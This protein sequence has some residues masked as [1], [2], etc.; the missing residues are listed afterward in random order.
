MKI[1][2]RILLPLVVALI[3]LASATSAMAQG[4]QTW[5]PEFQ[6]DKH[7]YIDSRL[8]EHR[9]NPV[10]LP[11]LP[12]EIERAQK[13]HG[14]K[15][16]VVATEQGSE[17][18]ASTALAAQKLD[19]LILK[20]RNDPN[21]PTDD[22]LVVMWVRFSADP[23]RGSVAANGGNRLRGYGMS[24][25]HFGASD[26]PVIP[27]LKQHMRERPELALTLIINNV[28]DEVTSAISAET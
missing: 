7:V 6:P 11:N 22:Y 19:E 8:E 2:N 15:V 28:N 23:T 17:A 9:T 21:F 5:M 13:V 3:A 26:G 14:L 16:Y 1:L 27:V 10:S 12:A 25:D 20:W 24:A 4:S 18:F